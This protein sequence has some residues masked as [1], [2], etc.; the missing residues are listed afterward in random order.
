MQWETPEEREIMPKKLNETSPAQEVR[1]IQ[2]GAYFR[3]EKTDGYTYIT[4]SWVWRGKK[5]KKDVGQ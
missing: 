1:S 2:M 3:G 4:T 5:K